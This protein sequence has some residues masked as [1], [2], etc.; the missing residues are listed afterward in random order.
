MESD[1]KVVHK[2]SMKKNLETMISSA[3]SSSDKSFSCHDGFSNSNDDEL[4]S[5]TEEDELERFRRREVKKMFDLVDKD[6]SG[7]ID[8]KELE[9]LMKSLSKN[10]S[11]TEVNEGFARVDTDLSGR[12]EFNEFYEWYKTICCNGS[13]TRKENLCN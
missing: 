3:F 11:R 2:A 1:F 4:S 5:D 8:R 13:D 10:F 9:T 7:Y 6:G 12:I